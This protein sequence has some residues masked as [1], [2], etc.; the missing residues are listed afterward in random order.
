MHERVD[1]LLHFEALGL[2]LVYEELYMWNRMH[3]FNNSNNI[4]TAT[5]GSTAVGGTAKAYGSTAAAVVALQQLKGTTHQLM[6]APQQ[7]LGALN[8]LLGAPQ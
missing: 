1:I 8:Q 2:Y 6:R 3:F 5:I 7:L 4:I